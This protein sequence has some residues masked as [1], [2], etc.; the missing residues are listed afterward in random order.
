MKMKNLLLIT[1]VLLGITAATLAQNVPSYVPTDGLVG[2]W[3]FNGNAND[4]SGNGNDGVV[5]GATLTEDRFGNNASAFHFVNPNDLIQVNPS[6]V[7]PLNSI[8]IFCWFRIENTTAFTH[9]I[10]KRFSND[11]SP[12]NSFVLVEQGPSVYDD[13]EFEIFEAD[14]FTDT[15]LNFT[16]SNN[17]VSTNSWNFIGLTYDGVSLRLYENGN[18][19]AEQAHSG[20]IQYNN[21]PLYF[22]GN[23]WNQSMIGSL[24]DIALFDRALSQEEITALY[25]SNICFQTITVTDTL[26]INIGITSFNPVSY[27]NTIKIFPNPSNDHITIDYGDYSS[28]SGYQLVIENSIGQE[29]F[30]ASINQQTSYIDLANWTGNGLYFVHIIDPQGNTIDIR[31]IVLQ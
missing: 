6:N 21:L 18:L 9:L 28:L 31:K 15:G 1:A 22:G 24:D 29:M 5:N 7:S 12:Y 26:L 4:E 20:T 11:G 30:Q 3:P 16:S 17:Q 10:S 8:S 13:Q 27:N 25:N 14:I 19:T 2:W 23:G